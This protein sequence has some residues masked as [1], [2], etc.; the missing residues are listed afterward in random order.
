MAKANGSRS[1]RERERVTYARIPE[2]MEMPYLIETQ[3]VSYQ[4]F[5]QEHVPPDLREN[6]G[7]QEA[8]TSVF[9]IQ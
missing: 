2:I 9:P 8:F 1:A 7:L 3:K 4:K 6:V 5:I